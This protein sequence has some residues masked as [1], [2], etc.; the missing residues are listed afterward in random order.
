MA[1]LVLSN[2][3]VVTMNGRREVIKNGAV[4]IE[5]DRTT[6]VGKTD[7]IKEKY[8]VNREIDCEDE[9][10]LPGF[11]DSH[12]HLGQALIRACADDMPLVPWL[13]ERVLPLQGIAYEEGD[14]EF[15]AKL[16]AL[17]MIKSRATTFVEALLHWKYTEEMTEAIV[18]SGMLGAISK[19]LMNRPKLC[20]SQW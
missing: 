3:T 19:S 13:E 5:G 10:I 9:L 20:R 11:I 18:E 8:S 15:S 6:D 1:D 12:V 16:C 7:E 17:E 4:A 2:G 14:G